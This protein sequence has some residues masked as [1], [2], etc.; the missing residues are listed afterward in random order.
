MF[1]THLNFFFLFPTHL[2]SFLMT[3]DELFV[4]NTYHIHLPDFISAFRFVLLGVIRVWILNVPQK[5]CVEGLVATLQCYS[6]VVVVKTLGGG[7]N[8]RKWGLWRWGALEENAGTLSF[9]LLVCMFV[10]IMMLAAHTPCH[11]IWPKTMVPRN[12]GLEPPNHE[13]KY[14]FPLFKS[15]SVVFCHTDGKLTNMVVYVI[16]NYYI[17]KHTFSFTSLSFYLRLKVLSQKRLLFS[18][19]LCFLFFFQW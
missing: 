15:F 16:I 12:H 14:T 2:L 4:Y 3:L 1:L 18:H 17:L 19:F 11:D 10:I 9:L 6:E 7:P 8:G 5:P 13:P